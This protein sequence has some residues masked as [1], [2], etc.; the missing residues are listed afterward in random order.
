MSYRK[1]ILI[2]FGAILLLGALFL[3]S[4]HVRGRQGLARWRTEA[5][6]RGEKLTLRELIPAATPE[7]N[8]FPALMAAA[9]HAGGSPD[10]VVSESSRFRFVAPGKVISTLRQEQWRLSKDDAKSVGFTNINWKMIA[11]R[12]ERMREPLAEARKAAAWPHFNAQLND[13]AGF[14]VRM[15]HLTRMKGLVQH[16]SAEAMVDLHQGRIPEAVD[17]MTAGLRLVKLLQEEPIVISQLVAEAMAAIAWGGTWRALDNSTLD[18]LQLARLQAAWEEMEFMRATALGL[19][20]E[21]ALFAKQMAMARNDLT[22]LDQQITTDYDDVM[23]SLGG[24]APSPSSQEI[25]EQLMKG[26][27]TNGRRYVLLPLLRFAWLDF[28]ELRYNETMQQIIDAHRNAAR[29]GSGQSALKTAAR[30]EEELGKATGLEVPR[31]RLRALTIPALTKMTRNAARYEAQKAMAIAAIALH[32]HRLRHGRYPATLAAL[33]PEFLPSVPRDFFDGAPLRY[34]L[35][36]DGT[37]VLYSISD[38][39]VDDGGNANPAKG[40]R[41]NLLNGLDLVWPTAATF[42][43]IEESSKTAK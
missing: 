41:P 19:E 24:T 7:Q 31:S 33:A 11:E 35:R 26:T 4:E 39:G 15:S 27:V 16:L 29:E 2:G 38:N 5:L 25:A 13:S 23:P 18:D 28:G 22:R 40:D 20:G 43:E 14:M 6:A 12:L 37:F 21:R 9:M 32:R 17:S 3:A 42:E 34:K 8:A 36:D 30:V 10:I 1:R